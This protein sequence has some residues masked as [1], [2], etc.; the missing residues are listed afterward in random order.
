VSTNSCLN[1]KINK[2][3]IPGANDSAIQRRN[4]D[5]RDL[6]PPL[7]CRPRKSQKYLSDSKQPSISCITNIGMSDN[8]SI[9]LCDSRRQSNATQQR[10]DFDGAHSLQG[11][12]RDS[13]SPFISR[14]RKMSNSPL[15]INNNENDLNAKNETLEDL[16]KDD[17]IN[18]S[19]DDTSSKKQIAMVRPQH[20]H[21]HSSTHTSSD[22]LSKFKIIY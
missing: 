21:H 13:N 8:R 4:V 5:L 6:P 16:R 15:Y 14:G 9:L 11:S 10:T 22:E 3:N 7:F 1:R 18:G 19:L 20:Q 2:L 17:N 12:F